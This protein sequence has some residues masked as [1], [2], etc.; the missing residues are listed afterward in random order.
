MLEKMD[1][2]H[3]LNPDQ[4]SAR[5]FR[6]GVIRLD[7]L[8][9]CIPGND[10]VHLLQKDFLAGLF[11]VFLELIGGKTL[12]AHRSLPSWMT[13]CNISDPGN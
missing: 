1:T 3:P 2:Q 6:L 12:L 9:Q 7:D 11:A 8:T 5:T 4:P 10:P 13:F